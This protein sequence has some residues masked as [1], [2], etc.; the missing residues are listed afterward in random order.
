MNEYIISPQE[1]SIL[2][3]TSDDVQLVDVRTIEKHNNF[4]IGGKHIPLEDLQERLGE[5]NP[6]KL[7]VT[8]CT[9]GGRSMV[10][11]KYLLSVGFTNVRSLDGGV[12]KWREENL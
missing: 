4:N 2:L 8:Y 11:L 5:L 9:M 6:N 12:T 10:A 3:Q 1:L 7:V